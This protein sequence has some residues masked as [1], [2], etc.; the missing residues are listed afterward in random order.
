MSFALYL[1]LI[2][3]LS[4]TPSVGMKIG[5]EQI[6]STSSILIFFVSLLNVLRYSN[7]GGLSLR[8]KEEVFVI[9]IALMDILI[10]FMLGQ[11][12]AIRSTLFFFIIPMLVSTLIA[13]ISYKKKSNV[14]KVVI[15]IY[16]VECVLAIYERIN[17]INFFPVVTEGDDI[18]AIQEQISEGFRSTALLGH[19]LNNALCVSII[20]GFIVC[21]K[22][23]KFFKISLILLGFVAILAFNARGAILIWGVI[24]GYI[25]LFSSGGGWKRLINTSLLLV[26]C[27]L[28]IFYSYDFL[29]DYGFGDRLLNDGIIDGSALT[30][31]EVFSSFDFIS[32]FDLW[33]GNSSNYAYVTNK[34]MAGGVEN[35]YITIVIRHGIVLGLLFFGA[36]YLLV[37]KLIRGYSLQ[38][39]VIIFASFILVGSTN[40]GLAVWLPWGFFLVCANSFLVSDQIDS[41]APNSIGSQGL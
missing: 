35:S 19:P 15:L 23:N 10:R 38:H 30:R 32:T 24:G 6:G 28:F 5:V 26:S 2:L 34:L 9:I 21:A 25:V 1:G 41:R 13:T 40:N 33:L 11:N 12:E 8:F 16:V 31:F 7:L 18:G 22:I 4:M 3:F 17:L 29:I 20:M 27:M 14:V 39:K 36:Y 37:K